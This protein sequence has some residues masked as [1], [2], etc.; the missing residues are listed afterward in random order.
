MLQTERVST[1]IHGLDKIIEGGFPQ[2]RSILVTGEPGTGKTI[3][4]LQFLVAGL[5]RGE[6]GIYVA[7]DEE[8]SDILE[9]GASL[10]WDLE[11]Y[12]ATKELAIL[13]AGTH[14]SALSAPGREKQIDVLRAVNDLAV[15]VTRLEAKRMV[16]DPAGPF[17][18]MR[19][20]ATRIQDQIRLLIKLLRKNLP[21]TNLLTSYAVPR[22]GE[23]TLHGVEEYLTAGV[24]VL[25]LAWKNGHLARSL[26]LEK[27]R[28]TD[29]KPAQYEFN[30][31]KGQGIVLRPN[32]ESES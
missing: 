29:V 25:E 31:V 21:T 13:N 7:S 11:K 20:T 2:G 10:G 27:M 5:A 15:H 8:P 16:L 17:V 23:M 4:S 14:I 1:G 3:C 32:P 24:V 18:L 22:T 28:C 9:Q 30:I 6:K 26:L 19:D 12:I